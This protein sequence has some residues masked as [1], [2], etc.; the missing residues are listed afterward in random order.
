MRP[1]FTL[2]CFLLLCTLL[3]VAVGIVSDPIRRSRRDAAL[4]ERILDAFGKVEHAKRRSLLP[5]LAV[6]EIIGVDLAGPDDRVDP[7]LLRDIAQLDSLRT[8]RLDER[9]LTPG[10]VEV[11]GTIADLEHLGLCGAA[12]DDRHIDGLRPLTKL[13]SLDLAE[14]GVTDKCLVTVAALSQLEVLSVAATGVTVDALAQLRLRRLRII[15]ASYCP[16]TFLDLTARG[17]GGLPSLQALSIRGSKIQ[18]VRLDSHEVMPA[19][20]ALN[21]RTTDLPIDR[22]SDVLPALQELAI[23]SPNITSSTVR[24]LR[25]F[26]SLSKLVASRDSQILYLGEWATVPVNG[27][28]IYVAVEVEREVRILFR[29]L[30]Q[31]RPTMTIVE[32]GKLSADVYERRRAYSGGGHPG[33]GFF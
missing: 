3:A 27:Q 22:L 19:L 20:T 17:F 8:L 15:D 21:L 14:T 18:H 13:R 16:G 12:V 9:E 10:D 28:S 32:D 11:I 26:K 4:T 2:A 25:R 6:N 31:L 5:F 7:T 1:R 30:L 29:E 24:E 33:T 23:E